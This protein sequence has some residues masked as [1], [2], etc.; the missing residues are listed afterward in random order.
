VMSTSADGTTWS[1]VTRVPIDAVTSTVDHFTPGLAIARNTSGSAAVIGLSYNF[2]PISNCT[3]NCKLGVGYISSTDGGSTWTAPK[4]LSEGMSPSWLPSTTSGQMLGD[5]M[6][7]EYNLKAHAIFPKAA[8]PVGT[9][10]NQATQTNQYVLSEAGAD[11]PRF[12]SAHDKRVA[13]P[14]SDV[15]R[16]TQP[17][18]EDSDEK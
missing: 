5:Y 9:T 10:L 14:H 12:T 4:T 15:P 11:E 2:L 1:S 6:S 7:V 16:R 3:A 8:A 17:Y 18:H 13:N